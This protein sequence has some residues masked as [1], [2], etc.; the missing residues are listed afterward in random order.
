MA[1]VFMDS[2]MTRWTY[3]HLGVFIVTESVDALC[4][5]GI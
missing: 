1:Q 5:V 4:S 2:Q 3:K